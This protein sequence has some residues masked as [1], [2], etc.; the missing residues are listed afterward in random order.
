MSYA[1]ALKHHNNP[2]K[3][4]RTRVKDSRGMS[5]SG[6]RGNALVFGTLITDA[7]ACADCE[8]Y[9]P[10]DDMITKADGRVICPSCQKA[11]EAQARERSQGDLFTSQPAL[12]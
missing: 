6:R 1:K 9:A 8:Q 12:F 7:R 10:T 5:L 2:R 11:I 4:R 3:W